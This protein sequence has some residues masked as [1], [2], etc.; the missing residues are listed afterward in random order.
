LTN[1]YGE[2]YVVANEPTQ[3]VNKLE[4]ELGNSDYGTGE[5]RM[6][7]KIELISIEAH[8]FPKGQLQFTKTD[9]LLISTE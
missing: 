7:T 1:E 4:Y 2:F 8:E 6:V 9:R 5:G 3:A